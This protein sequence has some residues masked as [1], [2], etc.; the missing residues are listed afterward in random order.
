VNYYNEVL[1]SHLAELELN[2]AL[3]LMLP[4]PQDRMKVKR[5]LEE[6]KR[7]RVLK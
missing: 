7:E 2:K 4:N 1:K 6:Y 3:I 5:T